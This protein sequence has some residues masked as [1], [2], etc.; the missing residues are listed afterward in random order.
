MA[1]LPTNYVDDQLAESMGGRRHYNMT[2]DAYGTYLTD[3]TEYTQRGST[4]AA[5]QINET[6]TQVN[7]NTTAIADKLSKT[8]D[9]QNNTTTFT[10]DDTTS[11]PSSFT[12]IS[13]VNSG[14]THSSLFRKMSQ[15]IKNIRWL[16]NNKR[17]TGAY[18]TYRDTVTFSSGDSTSATSWTDVSTLSSGLTHATLL[19]RISTMMKN[20]RFLGGYQDLNSNLSYETSSSDFYNLSVFRVGTTVRISGYAKYNAIYRG[21][22]NLLFYI[23]N[24]AYRPY[25]TSIR[26]G[27]AYG[28][29]TDSKSLFHDLYVT[30][31]GTKIGIYSAYHDGISYNNARPSSSSTDSYYLLVGSFSIVPK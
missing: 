24:Q 28:S 11:S 8:G 22:N 19:N 21:T 4:F 29:S 10:S 14:E 9:T 20:V 3:V 6:N 25:S 18:D 12:T 5:A 17:T 30:Y 16:N 15:A 7:A 26:I 31:T 13:L 1:T 23:E 27:Y 2:T